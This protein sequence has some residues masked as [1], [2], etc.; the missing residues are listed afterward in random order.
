MVYGA[1]AIA[2][3]VSLYSEVTWVQDTSGQLVAQMP[4]V[5]AHSVHNLDTLCALPKYLDTRYQAF[6]QGELPVADILNSPDQLALYVLA[7]HLEAG[8]LQGRLSIRS[9]LPLGAGMGSSASVIAALFALC[10]CLSHSRYSREQRYLEVRHCERLQHGKGSLIDAAAV[11]LGG[12]VRVQQ[13]VVEPVSLQL[14]D[15]WYWL[16]TGTP[17]SGTG[18]CVSTVAQAHGADAPLWQAFADCT[19]LFSNSL[20]QPNALLDVIAQNQA[21]LEY[22]GVVPARTVQLIHQLSDYGAAAKVSGAGAVRGD[23]SGLLLIYAPQDNIE[24][25][26]NQLNLPW[27]RL[28]Q[29]TTGAR[30]DVT[31]TNH[32]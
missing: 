32:Y 15:H 9:Q 7:R 21:L 16:F 28:K 29:D 10:E 11:I 4:P 5:S 12:A 13:Q 27:G 1:P 24:P 8:Q 26:L 23:A 18:E 20:S 30:I 25:F 2:T 6:E 17:Q 3:A 14:D 22:I 31:H 19:H